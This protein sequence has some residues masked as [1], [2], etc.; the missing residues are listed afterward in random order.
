MCG[1]IFVQ[2]FFIFRAVRSGIL[3]CVCVCACVYVY[4]RVC[5]CVHLGIDVRLRE[6]DNVRVDA[7]FYA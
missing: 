6:S 7:R 2:V 5:V 1:R 4:V 3:Q